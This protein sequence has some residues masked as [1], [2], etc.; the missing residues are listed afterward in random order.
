M[1]LPDYR[2]EKT[3]QDRVRIR[4]D[5]PVTK[6][7]LG[8]PFSFLVLQQPSTEIDTTRF[9]RVREI[10]CETNRWVSFL[11][12]KG[13]L[14]ERIE[15]FKESVGYV[16]PLPAVEPPAEGTPPHAKVEPTKESSAPA[17]GDKRA[18]ESPSK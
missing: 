16:E 11:K 9:G 13:V 12:T 15:E 3:G 2:F 1:T 5:P 7:N 18:V 17:P 6:S 14:T 10:V 4:F 8:V